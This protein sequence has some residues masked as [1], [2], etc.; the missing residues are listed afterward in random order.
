MP[1]IEPAAPGEEIPYVGPVPFERKHQSL[2]FG[3]THEANE[4]LSLIMAHPVALL[5]SQS[6][7]GKTSLLNASLI[8]MLEVEE[9]KV[10][11]PARVRGQFPEGFDPARTNPYIYNALASLSGARVDPSRPEGMTLSRHLKKT[12]HTDEQGHLKQPYVI[13][14]DQFEELFTL[15]PEFWRYRRGF[16]EQVAEALEDSFLRVVFAMREDYIAEMD[17]YESLLPEKLRTRFRLERLRKQSAMAAIMGP[18]H[19][20]PWSQTGRQFAPGVAEKLV[21]NLREI[22]SRTDQDGRPVK[23]EFVE[24]VQLQ[25]VCQAIWNNLEE[26]D[27]QITERHLEQFGDINQAL[28]TFYEGCVRRAVEAANVSRRPGEPQLFEG[29]LRAWF[30][31]VLITETGKRSMV[32]RGEHRTASVPNAAVDELEASHLIRAELREGERWYELSHDRFIQPIKE[33]YKRW[34]LDLPGAEQARLRL[35][36]KAAIWY[37]AGMGTAL[38]LDAGEVLEARRLRD[39][40]VAYT[41][42]LH[43]FVNASDASIRGIEAEREKQLAD[44][45]Q[46]AT[47]AEAQRAEERAQRIEAERRI[48]EELA[49]AKQKEVEQAQALTAEQRKATEA[50]RMRAEEQ[51]HRAEEKAKFSRRLTWALGAAVL[52]LLSTGVAGGYA[53]VNANAARMNAEAASRNA[54]EARINAEAAT[55][56]RDFAVTEGK[57]ANLAAEDAKEQSKQA[58]AQRVIAEEKSKEAEKERQAAVRLAQIAKE[59]ERKAEDARRATDR[60][61]DDERQARLKAESALDEAKKKTAQYEQEQLRYAATIPDLEAKL[62]EALVGKE[63]AES[64]N[65]TLQ[66]ALEQSQAEVKKLND[67]YQAGSIT[68]KSPDD[69]LRL[70]LQHE[71]SHDMARAEA[72]YLKAIDLTSEKDVFG[73]ATVHQTLAEFYVRKKDYDKALNAYQTVLK[74]YEDR[75]GNVETDPDLASLYRKFSSIL[76]AKAVDLGTQEGVGVARNYLEKALALYVSLKDYDGQAVTF[77]AV[78]D[79]YLPTQDYDQAVD[80][81]SKAKEIYDHHTHNLAGEAQ[82]LF[83]IGYAYHAKGDKLKAA[84]GLNNEAR[85]SYNK[86]IDNYKE[87]LD[88]RDSNKLNDIAGQ[89][90]ACTNLGEVYRNLE[91]TENASHYFSRAQQLQQQQQQQ[92]QRSKPGRRSG[93]AGAQPQ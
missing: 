56:Q 38:L 49:A 26:G 9:F 68:P 55:V 83:N 40:G 33:S 28:T 44:E 65:K 84:H 61:K 12:Q 75:I 52:L 7:A 21:E 20:E 79:T 8:P 31:G 69:F 35:E 47:E 59:E 54:E 71:A 72:S 50:Q 73:Q 5:Y 45:R 93:K 78:G 18:L 53:V 57:R 76:L 11:G 70:G 81:Y 60:A 25:V 15:N 42:R 64:Q 41:D 29:T 82:M 85:D 1:D 3:R 88:Q 74:V 58:Q 17:P 89:I 14:F 63:G 27:K 62:K 51:E 23:G 24:P 86:A 34:L 80:S 19:V 66:A 4:L 43:A 39:S 37:G 46:K 67:K 2:F 32:F 30:D 48:A 22:P 6:G 91:D 16:F 77:D 90:A 87:S 13:V 10:I 92:Q 36:E